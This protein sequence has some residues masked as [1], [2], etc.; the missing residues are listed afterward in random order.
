MVGLIGPNGSGK[1]SLL[2]VLATCA[3]RC[4]AVRYGGKSAREMGRA[5]LRAASPIWRRRGVHWP[6]RVEALVALGRLPPAA[7]AGSMRRSRGD[8]AAL[9]ACDVWRSRRT[10]SEV[11]A[12]SG[13]ASFWRALAVEATCC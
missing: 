11:S 12:A 3:R 8:R 2:R 9:V 13:C 5:S 4:R 1:T 7:H 10:M 6:M